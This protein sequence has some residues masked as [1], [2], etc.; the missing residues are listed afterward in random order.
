M[1]LVNYVHIIKIDINSLID[2]KWFWILWIVR[3][4]WL[5]M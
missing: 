2:K 3:Y 5:W 1:K 4:I